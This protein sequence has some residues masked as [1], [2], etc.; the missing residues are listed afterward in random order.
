MIKPS[1]YALNIQF[2]TLIS[3]EKQS[4]VQS[5]SIKNDSLYSFQTANNQKLPKMQ[6]I[7]RLKVKPP[8]YNSSTSQSSTTKIRKIVLHSKR[9]SRGKYGRGGSKNKLILPDGNSGDTNFNQMS[10]TMKNFNR[11]VSQDYQ[12]RPMDSQIHKSAN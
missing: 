6:V 7:R 8:I 4:Q 2:D 9:H 10:K 3:E 5:S 12:K 1:S 11:E